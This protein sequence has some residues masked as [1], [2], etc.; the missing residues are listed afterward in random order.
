MTTTGHKAGSIAA[1]S[2]HR[3]FVAVGGQ[4]VSFINHCYFLSDFCTSLNNL[5]NNTG[6]KMWTWR[7]MVRET[8]SL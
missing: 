5:N 6:T 4:Q 2:C 3:G 7:R 8:L 1:Y